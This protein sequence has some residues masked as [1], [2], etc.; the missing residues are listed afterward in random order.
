MPPQADRPFGAKGSKGHTYD[1]YNTDAVKP[2]RTA[3][4]QHVTLIDEVSILLRFCRTLR[5]VGH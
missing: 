5:V 1:R 3:I 4:V 2:P